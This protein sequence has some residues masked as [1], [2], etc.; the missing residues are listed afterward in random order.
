MK[1]HIEKKPTKFEIDQLI[2]LH[3]KRDFI[4]LE[5]DSRTL[6]DEYPNH[7]E[8]QNLF[9]VALAGQELYEDSLKI[10]FKAI[11]DA[12]K[13]QAKAKILNN[14]GV[15]YIKLDDQSNAIIYLNKAINED[16][17]NVSAHFNLANALRNIGDVESSLQI[18]ESALEIDPMHANSVIYYSLA[19]K[20]L[21]RFKDSILF[22]N[23]ALEIRQDW[24]MAHR[25]LSSMTKYQKN[26]DHLQIMLSLVE[27]KDLLEEDKMHLCFGLSKAFEDISEYDKAFSFL[28]KANDLY[29]KEIKFS[30]KNS[31][32][33]FKAIKS[34]FSKEFCENSKNENSELGEGIIFILGMPRSGTSLV[35]QILSSHS[36]VFGAGELRHFRKSV[37]RIFLEVD[38]KKFPHNV[39]LYPKSAFL[40]VGRGYENMISSLRGD[41]PFFVDKMPYNFM[42]LPLIKLSLPKSKIVLTERNPIDNCLSIYKQKFGIGNAYAYN[43]EELAEYFNSYKDIVENW[44]EIYSEQIFSLNYEQLTVNQK[45][46]TANLLEFCNLDWEKA[47]LEFHKTDRNNKTAS[48]FQVRQPLYS[49]SVK[50]WKNYE[51]QL[52][53]L[54]N[55]LKV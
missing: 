50:L 41:S 14:V 34:V 11:V 8:V 35:E 30:T 51:E 42:Y 17:N 28:S 22:C 13:G 20:I 48:S 49:S 47:C 15:S 54:I 16:P 37:D 39:N 40:E 33:W 24:G 29:R 18:Y 7:H 9:G 32:N 44:K 26:R 45:E 25:H 52:S 23:K 46:V 43:Q 31:N 36:K 53:P 4:G 12:D 27:N 1:P 5:K 3:E 10:F 2:K 19:L 6:L 38:G 55:T 21:G